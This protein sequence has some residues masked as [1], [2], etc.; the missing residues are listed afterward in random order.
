MLYFTRNFL[1]QRETF[2][3]IGK[4]QRDYAHFFKEMGATELQLPKIVGD[5]GASQLFSNLTMADTVVFQYP[6]FSGIQLAKELIIMEELEKKG[7]KI[8]VFVHDIYFLRADQYRDAAPREIAMLNRADVVILHSQAMADELVKAGLT[9]PYVIQG[10]FGYRVDDVAAIDH[11]VDAKPERWP[12]IYT[13]SMDKALFV[14][15]YNLH[16]PIDMFGPWPERWGNPQEKV[17]P[18]LV[19]KGVVPAEELP[20]GDFK[21]L[22]LV[23]D[24]RNNP[25]TYK[26]ATYTRYNM[27]LKFSNYLAFELPI[28][29]WKEAA[30]AEYVESQGI[31]F[32]LNR[33]EELDAR[34]DA[35]SLEDYQQMLANVKSFAA[36]IRHGETLKVAV[37]QALEVLE[38][39]KPAMP[40]R[41]E[42]PKDLAITIFDHIG[43]Y[44]HNPV[45]ISLQSLFETQGVTSQILTPHNLTVKHG[46]AD[47]HGLRRGNIWSIYDSL[48][49]RMNLLDRPNKLVDFEAPQG[50]APVVALDNKTWVDMANDQNYLTIDLRPNADI[51]FVTYFENGQ[52]TFKDAYDD[53]GHINRREYPDYAAILDADGEHVVEFQGDKVIYLP[54]NLSFENETAFMAWAFQALVAQKSENDRFI[55]ASQSLRDGLIHEWFDRQGVYLVASEKLGERA[56]DIYM[57]RYEKVIFDSQAERDHWVERYEDRTDTV[58]AWNN[59]IAFPHQRKSFAGPKR[60]YINLMRM[61]DRLNYEQVADW[62]SQVHMKV[63]NLEFV[64]QTEMKLQATNFQK[65]LSDDLKAVTRVINRPR[66]EQILDDL[67]GA[68]AYLDLHDES[69]LSR[70]LMAAI[71]TETPV[72]VLSDATHDV[73]TYDVT[74][75]HPTQLVDLLVS[76]TD[77]L[78]LYDRMLEGL[79]AKADFFGPQATFA[80]WTAILQAGEQS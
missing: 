21:G 70:E 55:V 32:A 30:I 57:D 74:R 20:L 66:I 17:L 10:P 3:A 67:R 75:V 73:D 26:I 63:S 28:I 7:V 46:A 41:Q 59:I 29:V 58:L 61:S 71:S 62:L 45:A 77:G 53:G 60:I 11:Q 9:K 25:T 6:Q 35:L 47:V 68:R 69:Y 37:K 33:L 42:L 49:G 50:Y 80:R 16:T 38:S 78:R 51:E 36:K 5:G 15:D 4:V 64:V 24:G 79:G 1:K 27:P 56:D 34:L 14:Q 19:Y 43:I 2:N 52:Q 23:W 40:D 44:D 12:L 76:L 48:S 18:P 54:E 65:V 31:G 39:A 22:S 8:I 13:G 72:F